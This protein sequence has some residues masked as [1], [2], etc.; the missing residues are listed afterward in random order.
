MPVAESLNALLKTECVHNLVT[1][2]RGGLKSVIC[3][4]IAVAERSDW[5]THRRLYGE[6][7]LSP[8][9]S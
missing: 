4:E 5:L 2:P 1:R 7:A 9:L 6:I 3:V 8:P